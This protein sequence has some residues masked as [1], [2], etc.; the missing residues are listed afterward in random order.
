[1]RLE[2]FKQILKIEEHQSFSKAAKALFISQPSFSISINNFEEELGFK[3][4]ER[5]NKRVVPTEQGK[6]ILS[7]AKKILD[8]EEKIKGIM[9]GNDVLI[10]NLH[11]A[12]PAALA[13]AVFSQILI[14]FR[15]L[16]P[17]VNL[18]IQEA[19]FYEIIDMMEKGVYSLGVISSPKSQEQEL[20]RKLTGKGIA[21]EIIPGADNLNMTLFI[22]SRN[23]LACQESVCLTDF[24]NLISISYKD[25]FTIALKEMDDIHKHVFASSNQLSPSNKEIIVQDIEL[26]KML[27]SENLGYA[28]FPKIFAMNNLYVKKGLIQA[29]PIRE[30]HEPHSFCILYFSKEPLSLIEK[31]LLIHVRQSLKNI[32]INQ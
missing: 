20:L 9:D 15:E 12:V 6:E 14:D 11:I 27:I 28:V 7:L 1:M 16:Y 32:I 4:F 26:V 25:N 5:N 24:K 19:R 29:L 10:R 8:V 21:C 18:H 22:S 2:Q 17:S 3:L 30:F 23:P 13:N 31:E